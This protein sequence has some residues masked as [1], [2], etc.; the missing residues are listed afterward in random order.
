MSKN[1]TV[2]SPE[3]LLWPAVLALRKLGGSASHQE[4]IEAVVDLEGIPEEVQNIM[5]APAHGWTKLSFNLGVV[6]INLG[7]AGILDVSRATKGMW[8]LTEKGKTV[9]EK[10]VQ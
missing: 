2:P 5:H 3:S 7:K 4:L 9:T 1:L 8:I 6:K 10:D